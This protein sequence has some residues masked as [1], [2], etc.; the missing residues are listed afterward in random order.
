MGRRISILRGNNAKDWAI[1][2]QV[3]FVANGKANEKG[4]TSRR[5]SGSD[6]VLATHEDS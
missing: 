6:D 4:S 2:S 5:K 1:R 3:L